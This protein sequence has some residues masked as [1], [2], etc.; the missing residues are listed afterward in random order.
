MREEVKFGAK[1]RDR[2]GSEKKNSPIVKPEKVQFFLLSVNVLRSYLELHEY[3]ELSGNLNE[4]WDKIRLVDDW[5]F[6]NFLVGN[7]FI[8]HAPH[9]HIKQQHV[10]ELIGYHIKTLRYFR[11][12]DRSV[13]D[14]VRYLIK[15]GMIDMPAFIHFITLFADDFDTENHQKHE[16]DAAW[17][18]GK[19]GARKRQDA[20]GQAK[21]QGKSRAEAVKAMYVGNLHTG[22]DVNE[23]KSAPTNSQNNSQNQSQSKSGTKT[24]KW[25]KP[26]KTAKPSAFDFG[27]SD[28]ENEEMDISG[29]PEEMQDRLAEQGQSNKV[30]KIEELDAIE[31]DA[32]TTWR[33]RYYW[34]KWKGFGVESWDPNAESDFVHSDFKWKGVDQVCAD[35]VKTLQW[36]TH[37]YFNGIQSWAWFYPHH[38]SPFLTDVARMLKKCIKNP[39]FKDQSIENIVTFPDDKPF[40]PFQQLMGVLPPASR[41]CLPIPYHIFMTDEKSPIIDFYPIDFIHDLNGK[42]QDW[43]AVVCIP[44]IDEKRL[45]ATIATCDDKLT[46]YERQRN[47]HVPPTVFSRSEERVEIVINA[48]NSKFRACE[49]NFANAVDLANMNVH[50]IPIELVNRDTIGFEGRAFTPGFPYLDYIPHISEYTN[51]SVMV[52]EQASNNKSCVLFVQNEENTAEDLANKLL[53]PD[54]KFKTWVNWPHMFKAQVCEV[55]DAHRTFYP[56]QHPMKGFKDTGAEHPNYHM[57]IDQ[58]V[59]DRL[60]KKRGIDAKDYTVIARVKPRIGQKLMFISGKG[61]EVRDIFSDE[62]EYHLA[63]LIQ[64]EG[65]NGFKVRN[66]TMEE[67][68]L[69]NGEND[70]TVPKISEIPGFKGISDISGEISEDMTAEMM[71]AE[72]QK[73]A[74]KATSMSKSNNLSYKI[75]TQIF[76]T[77][78]KHQHFGSHGKVIGIDSKGKIQAELFKPWYPSI[79]ETAQKASEDYRRSKLYSTQDLCH[80]FQCSFNMVNIFV[81]MTLFHHGEKAK[82]LMSLN[83]KNEKHKTYNRRYRGVFWK[84]MK[85]APESCFKKGKTVSNLIFR[86]KNQDFKK[87]PFPL[88]AQLR[89]R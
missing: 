88:R 55:F 68:Y 72:I 51:A 13:S 77:N 83:C 28:S 25:E 11:Q 48:P 59:Q 70:Q 76:I 32:F 22:V 84:W 69:V 58:I 38:Y 67:T 81:S 63:E 66:S 64:V 45:T 57:L 42:D 71:L 21:A 37:Y 39:N 2:P 41:K 18:G 87:P 8:P 49:I 47:R 20:F 27:D 79:K 82:T 7:D 80:Q 14:E 4:N 35:Y 9:L 10:P 29:L 3:K 65:L 6:L 60:Y 15:D 50:R 23:K 46:D 52:F 33:Q 56:G 54:A 44:F 17:L 74:S 34:A 89:Q 40:L 26:R 75:G 12:K 19:R 73:S 24:E 61:F 85:L 53:N 16:A 36:I 43:E 86:L 62:Y 30:T 5:I 78:D 31:D 1:T